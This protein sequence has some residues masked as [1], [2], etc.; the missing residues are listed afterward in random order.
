M[1]TWRIDDWSR[2]DNQGSN[3]AN[4]LWPDHSVPLSVAT[5]MRTPTQ[6]HMN[7]FTGVTILNTHSLSE[8]QTMVWQ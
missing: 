2:P 1:A 8:L 6:W 7:A 3:V 4:A 5:W